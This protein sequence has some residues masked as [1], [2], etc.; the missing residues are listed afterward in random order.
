[1]GMCMD[2]DDLMIFR[3]V[4]CIMSQC[5]LLSDYEHFGLLSGGLNFIEEACI[6][7]T[8]VSGLHTVLT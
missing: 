3:V 8:L 7:K 6:F 5:N 1:M 2:V 4:F